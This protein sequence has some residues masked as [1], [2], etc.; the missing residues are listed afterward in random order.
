[1]VPVGSVLPDLRGR[2]RDFG[3]RDRGVAHAFLTGVFAALKGSQ[4]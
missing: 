3:G 2:W 4:F 1:M